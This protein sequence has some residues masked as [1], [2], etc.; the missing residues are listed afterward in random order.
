MRERGSATIKTLI[1]LVFAAALIVGVVKI[2]PVY[3]NVYEFEDAMR[4]QAKFAGVERKDASVIRE[5]LYKKAR[6]L[7]LPITPDQI[8]VDKRMGGVNIKAR[9]TV[10]V[11]LIVMQRD[12]NFS[13][14]S[15]T[16]TAF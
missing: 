3:V 4:Q 5:E 10:P 15:D 2:V 13:L 6:D 16:S 8:E 9:F 7:K 1:A 11:D 12:F 14:E